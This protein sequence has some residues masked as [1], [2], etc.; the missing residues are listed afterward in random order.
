M[1]LTSPV[2][3]GAQTGF[4][5]PTYTVV[6]DL[7]PTPQGR[8]YA[9]SAVGGTQTGVDANSVSKPFTVNMVRPA[10][11]KQVGTV[12]PVT[13]VLTKNPFNEWKIIFR[14]GMV[15]LTGQS[16]Q[17]ALA[18]LSFS[19]PSGSDTAEPEEIRALVSFI[20]GVLSQQSAAIAQT[21]IDG[22]VTF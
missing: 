13:G 2:T 9:V 21:M 14:K 5:S 17:T 18:A 8:Q 15:P 6:S 19:I 22:V 20:V 4:T 1:S 7:A 16:P 12:N 10:N 3:G 11:F